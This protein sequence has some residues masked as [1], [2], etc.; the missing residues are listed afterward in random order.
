MTDDQGCQDDREEEEVIYFLLLYQEYVNARF[1]LLRL[2]CQKFEGNGS[3]NRVSQ[4]DAAGASFP[5]P[6]NL[7]S[8][9]KHLTTGLLTDG[10]ISSSSFFIVWQDGHGSQLLPQLP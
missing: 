7:T 9:P 1:H 2:Q 3:V 4:C 5:A 8:R 10:P 6:N